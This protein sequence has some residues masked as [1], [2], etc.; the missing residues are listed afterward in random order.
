[1]V[2]MMLEVI[3]FWLDLKENGN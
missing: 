2:D 3:N 1:M